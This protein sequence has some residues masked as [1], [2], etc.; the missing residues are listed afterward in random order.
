MHSIKADKPVPPLLVKLLTQ[1]D[2]AARELRLLYF[3]GGAFARDLL[4]V[5]VHGFNIPRPTRDVDIG[6]AVQSWPEFDQL[7]ARLVATGE[8]STDKS[9]AQRLR[10]LASQTSQGT[11][12][13]I[14]PFAGVEEAGSLLRWPPDRGVVMNVAGFKEALARREEVRISDSLVVP[15]ASL[16]GQTLLKLVAW[17]DRRNEDSRDAVDLLTLFRNYGDAGNND[18]LYDE[19]GALLESVEYDVER[20]GASLLGEDVRAIAM[21]ESYE[22]LRSAFVSPDIQDALVTNVSSS[23][24]FITTDPVSR[25]QILIDAFLGGL[26]TSKSTSP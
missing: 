4:L 10:F 11:P 15:V 21:P 16:P 9:I 12:L 14:V 1:V 6:V 22:Q 17:L 20:A 13:D 24:A 8:F 19:R 23:V 25:A 18:R 5:H 26:G 2:A 3:V 7:K